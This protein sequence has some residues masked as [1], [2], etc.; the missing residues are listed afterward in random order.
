MVENLLQSDRVRSNLMKAASQQVYITYAC[1]FLLQQGMWLTSTDALFG[2]SVLLNVSDLMWNVQKWL[3]GGDQ[4]T[5]HIVAYTLFSKET[6]KSLDVFNINC[7][8]PFF[9]WICMQNIHRTLWEP[10]HL[11][12]KNI[13]TFCHD[14]GMGCNKRCILS[15]QWYTRRCLNSLNSVLCSHWHGIMYFLMSGASVTATGLC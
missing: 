12:V 15:G 5:D 3:E 9:Y 8:Y 11:I 14:V 2:C 4:Q 6:G 1:E 10:W 13:K 7:L